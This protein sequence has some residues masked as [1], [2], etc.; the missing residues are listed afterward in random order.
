LVSSFCASRPNA[1]YADF[2]VTSSSFRAVTASL[3]VLPAPAGDNF[4]TVI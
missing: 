1:R 4:V 2:D 3:F